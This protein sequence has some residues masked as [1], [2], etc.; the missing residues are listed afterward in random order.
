MASRGA[1]NAARRKKVVVAAGLPVLPA[2]I[3]LAPAVA[4]DGVRDRSLDVVRVSEVMLTG[5]PPAGLMPL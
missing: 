2:L 5:S 1:L 3:V 4:G